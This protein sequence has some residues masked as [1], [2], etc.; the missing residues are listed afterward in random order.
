MGF[1]WAAA[2]GEYNLGTNLLSLGQAL[3]EAVL[4]RRPRALVEKMVQDGAPLW[5]QDE[6]GTSALHA[7][8]YAED[9]ALIRYLIE[10]GAVWNAGECNLR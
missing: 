4:E 9:E 6:E 7:A 5:Y 10:Q 8:A 2:S 1:N 3:V